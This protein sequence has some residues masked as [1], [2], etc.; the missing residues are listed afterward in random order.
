MNLRNIVSVAKRREAVE[1]LTATTLKHIGQGS[2]NEENASTHNCENM[3]GVV[4]I[5][6]GIAGPIS[7]HWGEKHKEYMI[8]LATTEGALVASINRG[9]K[10]IVQSGGSYTYIKRIGT[11]RA[12]VFET[13]SLLESFQFAEQVK[14]E[15]THLQY[16]AQ[17]TSSHI[18]LMNITPTVVGTLVYVHCSFNTQDAMGMNMVT[19]ACQEISTYLEQRFSMKCLSVSGN[20]CVDKKPSWRNMILGR[21]FSAWSEVYIPTTII[22]GVL[23]TTVDELYRTYESKC[24]IGSA[25]SGS[26]GFNGH[27]ANVI[28]AIFIAT[29]QDPAHVVEG[30]QTITTM[31]KEEDGVRISVSIPSLLL[32]TVGGGTGLETQQESLQILGI[33]GGNEGKNAE[34]FAS[35]VSSAVLAGE[36]SELAALSTG[37]LTSAHKSLARGKSL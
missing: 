4:Q 10:A 27:A 9:C 16:I 6:L 8:P 35:I 33:A 22:T 30:S 7:V 31:K 5:P 28:A 1:S 37:T 12:P 20:T 36:I 15:F 3:I 23:K 18:L 29:G 21:G 34:E 24:L 17:Q 32:G 13:Q 14:N 26:I 19:I 2:L 25:I 11:T